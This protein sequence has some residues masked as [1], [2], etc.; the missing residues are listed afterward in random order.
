MK[1]EWHWFGMPG[2][3]PARTD[4]DDV[5]D[6]INASKASGG[7]PAHIDMGVRRLKQA[8]ELLPFIE[9]SRANGV[10]KGVDT[11]DGLEWAV[12]FGVPK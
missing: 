3:R 4:C 6:A 12:S 8:L 7:R 2:A 9:Y 11:D 10:I 1:Q 5:Q